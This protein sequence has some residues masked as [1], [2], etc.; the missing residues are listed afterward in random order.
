MI[1]GRGTA[2]LAVVCDILWGTA[3]WTQGLKVGAGSIVITPGQDMWLSGYASRTAPSAGKVHDLYAKA[4]VFE[5]ATGARSAI[6]TSD[7]IGL[8]RDI[9][10]RA[11]GLVL[12]E[13]GIPRE[14]LMITASHTHTG[15]ALAGNLDVMFDLDAEQARLVREYTDALPAKFL[16]AIRQAVDDLAESSLEYV[17]G[18][19]GF[20]VNRRQYTLN[21]V[22]IGVNPIGPVDHSVPML[23]VRRPDGTPRAVLLA[24]ACHNT[25]LSFQQ[26]CGDYA[27]FAQI[28]VEDKLPGI[29]ALFASG[30][31]ADANPNPRGTLPL[32]REHGEELGAAVVRGMERGGTRISGS[33]AAEF[34]EIELPL[35]PPPR[36]DALDAQLA[37]PNM[38]I[39]RRARAL[40]REWDERG[41]LATTKRYPI[42][43]WRFGDGPRVIALG[44]E[45]V[46]D[47]ALRLKH[48]F[49]AEPAIVLGYANDVM[50][51]IPSLRVLREGGYEAD[52]SNIY[53]GLYGP[54]AP[55]IEETIIRTVHELAAP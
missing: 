12:D 48:E 3:A 29:T 42:Q 17:T 16:G 23:I 8:T 14:R 15:P 11:A 7:L 50:A 54:W 36:R 55:E 28:Y 46:V 27:G 32:A 5:D 4:L 6:V 35:S 19:A 1:S 49:G 2:A 43:V 41:A 44:G 20:A 9:S 25:T 18:E 31:G 39:Q 45:V 13:F 22:V 24:Y 10:E 40:L 38:F 33:I 47:Y 30:C 52:A 21:G 37:D 53:Y 26:I 34:R 51:Y